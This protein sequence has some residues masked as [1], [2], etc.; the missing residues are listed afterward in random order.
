MRDI[1]LTIGAT[2][3][4]RKVILDGVDISH[5]VHTVEIVARPDGARVR[6]T[7][8]ADIEGDVT[9]EAQEL[10]RSVPAEVKPLPNLELKVL[11]NSGVT[12]P[13]FAAILAGQEVRN[14]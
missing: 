3:Q 5:T 2:W 12:V 1:K 8:A 6:L 7:L 13:E 11:V 14:A 4:D 10:V 9:G